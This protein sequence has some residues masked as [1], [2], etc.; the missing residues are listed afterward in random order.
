MTSDYNI[1]LFQRMISYGSETMKDLKKIKGGLVEEMTE[2]TWESNR[3]LRSRS[4]TKW[5]SR[6]RTFPRRARQTCRRLQNPSWRATSGKRQITPRSP[7]RLLWVLQT[8][9]VEG[10]MMIKRSAEMRQCKR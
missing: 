3:I 7:G 10:Q 6:D 8:T 5:R 1:A 4:Q 9:D 2:F